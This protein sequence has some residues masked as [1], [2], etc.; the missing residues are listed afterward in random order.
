[1]QRLLEFWKKQSQAKMIAAVVIIAVILFVGYKNFG[2]K[3]KKP[4]YQTA[5]VTKGTLLTT[6]SESGNVTSGSQAG[7][8]SPTTGIIQ[9]IYVKDGDTVKQGQNLF[10]VA[11]TATAQERSSALAQYLSAQASLNSANTSLYNLQSTMF[12]K[13]QTYMN[14]ATNTTYQ[15]SDSTP[16]T[17]ARVQTPFTIA[18]DDWLATEAQYKNQQTVISQAQ[19]S[20]NN[21]SLAYKATQNAVVTAPIA[22]TVANLTVRAGDQITA[23]GGNLSSNVSS[24]TATNAVLYIGNYA[25]PYIKVQAG[26]VDVP[27]IH[28][29]EKA[30]I[31]LDAFPDKTFVGNVDQ[32]DTTG[33]ISSGVV[34][35]NVFV[36]I[37]APADNI[38]PGMSASVTIQTNRKDDVLSVPS[39]AVQTTNGQ[40]TVRI[41]KNGTPTSVD[42]QTGLVSDTQ[43]EITSGLSEG[44]TV[45]TGTTSTTTTTQTGTS[46]FARTFGGGGFGGGGGARGG[47]RGG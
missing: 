4:Q 34:T 7:V 9:D 38:M 29:G 39:A 3:T 31:T 35:Y 1:M 40:S 24:T 41:M 27:N 47:G 6:V 12:A 2:Q 22:G 23:S 5:Q 18:Q 46:P 30:T 11:S 14:T 28:A 32:V 15:N 16:N 37:V 44:D 21:A 19:A 26:E 36:S 10:K 8:G 13:W 42:V 43:T 17:T 45:V 33:A 20:L 25:K